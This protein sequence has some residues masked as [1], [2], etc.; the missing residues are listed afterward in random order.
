MVTQERLKELFSYDPEAGDFV[1]LVGRPGP[2][3]RAGDVA[4]CDNGQGYVR[5]Y[6]DGHG[7][8]AHRLAWLYVHGEWPKH[9][10]HVNGDRADNRI[11]NLRSVNQ[12]QNNMNLPVYKNNTSGLRG[13]SFYKRTGRWKA[14]IQASGKKIG[15][16]Y[17]DTPDEAHAAYV[18]AA[19]ELHGEFAR[20]H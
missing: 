5:I 2:N 15:L 16:G 11:D 8:K 13:V 9:I 17:F 7:Y 3:A 12:Q 10:D 18:S 4:G 6:V 20:A 19:E 14:Q 1:R